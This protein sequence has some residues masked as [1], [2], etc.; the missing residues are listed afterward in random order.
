MAARRLDSDDRL[1][2]EAAP[3]PTARTPGFGARALIIVHG[4]GMDEARVAIAAGSLYGLSAS[5]AA[6]AAQLAV[7]RSPAAI[8]HKRGVSLGTIRTQV[9]RIYEK[10]GVTSQLELSAR[11]PRL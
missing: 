2:I 9:R 5:V 3:L 4:P 8:A 10:V 11:L 1:F 6:V 7:G